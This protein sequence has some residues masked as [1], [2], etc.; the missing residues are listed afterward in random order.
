MDTYDI[1]Y[2]NYEDLCN[3]QYLLK[4]TIRGKPKELHLQPSCDEFEHLL[5]L[6]HLK[7]VKPA[8]VHTAV[9]KIKGTP[10]HECDDL[11]EILNKSSSSKVADTKKRIVLVS[12]LS[13]ILLHS[14]GKGLYIYSKETTSKR[15]APNINYDYIICHQSEYPEEYGYIFLKKIETD[16]TIFAESYIIISCFTRNSP[17]DL[18]SAGKSFCLYREKKLE[19][20]FEKK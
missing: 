5:G 20:I 3:D 15:I 9:E 13:N 1:L 4:F 10:Y 12:Q 17:Y 11:R 8:V 6:Q 7:D 18:Q 19:S 16:E 14:N 2:K